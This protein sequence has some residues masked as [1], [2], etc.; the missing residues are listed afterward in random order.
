M[1]SI[2]GITKGDTMGLDCSSFAVQRFALKRSIQ[3]LTWVKGLGFRGYGLGIKF[4]A[5]AE[6]CF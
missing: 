5:L 1:G 4:V 6:A 2:G 3:V